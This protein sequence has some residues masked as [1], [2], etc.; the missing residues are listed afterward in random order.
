MLERK[1]SLHRDGIP[2]DAEHA[3][4]AGAHGREDSPAAAA[5]RRAPALRKNAKPKARRAA[6]T[7][8]TPGR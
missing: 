7:R 6:K 5:R 8:R 3:M 1:K 2:P 4:V